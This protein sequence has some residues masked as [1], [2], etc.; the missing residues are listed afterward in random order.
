MKIALLFGA[1]GAI[2]VGALW[3]ATSLW[4]AA[5]V[6]IGWFGWSILTGGVLLT[7]LLGAGLMWLSFFSARHG[8]DQRAH[9][10]AQLLQQRRSALD[11]GDGEG[12]E[13]LRP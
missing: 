8:Y 7:V 3:A 13:T 1:L 2:L 11:R 9:D 12:D 4:T 6:E 10:A 5:G